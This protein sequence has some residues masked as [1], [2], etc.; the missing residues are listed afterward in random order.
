MTT[1]LIMQGLVFAVFCSFIADNKNRNSMAWFALGFLFSIV[2]LIALVGVSTLDQ[3]QDVIANQLQ[4]RRWIVIMGILI[5]VGAGL[6][7][8]RQHLLLPDWILSVVPSPDYKMRTTDEQFTRSFG[9]LQTKYLNAPE[10]QQYS[11][12]LEKISLVE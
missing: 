11:G 10:G 6:N 8:S 1:L 9:A 3:T 7:Y 12:V 5:L 2:S 4:N